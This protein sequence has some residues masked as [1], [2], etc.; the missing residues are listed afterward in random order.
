MTGTLAITGKPLTGQEY[1]K[2]CIYLCS[3]WKKPVSLLRL[4]SQLHPVLQSE[5][6]QN[7]NRDTGDG[8]TWGG[9]NVF[10]HSALHHLDSPRLKDRQVFVSKP[11]HLVVFFLIPPGKSNLQSG[12]LLLPQK[13]L[14]V[15]CRWI[16]AADT[17]GCSSVTDRKPR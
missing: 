10:A 14:H 4:T 5:G 8:V 7:N 6:T 12:L 16:P 11:L 17:S 13:K 3:K 2:V 15:F 1:G 9:D